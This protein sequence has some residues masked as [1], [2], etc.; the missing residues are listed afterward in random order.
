M[1]RLVN[2]SPCPVGARPEPGTGLNPARRASMGHP[3][4]KPNAI[5]KPERGP[6]SILSG[7]IIFAV[8][9][10]PPERCE[11]GDEYPDAIIILL[12]TR[13]GPINSNAS[14]EESNNNIL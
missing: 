4:I 7:R 2:M 3:D 11:G 12:S 9:E 8:C 14:Q 5:P 6:R 13:R 10:E 1:V